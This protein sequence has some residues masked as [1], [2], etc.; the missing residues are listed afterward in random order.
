MV[1]VPP[2]TQMLEISYAAT[3]PGV[4]PAGRRRRRDAYLANRSTRFNDVN[5]TRVD[6]VN[7]QITRC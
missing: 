7:H 3:T 5:N 4:A 2:N 1:V 6:R